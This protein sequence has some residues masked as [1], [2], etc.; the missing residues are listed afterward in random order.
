MFFKKSAFVFS[1]L[2]FLLI[3]FLN[4]SIATAMDAGGLAWNQ[5]PPFII[6]LLG[7]AITAI[8]SMM[9]IQS[10]N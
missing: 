1:I 9:S 6:G 8:F 2:A 7:M 3:A 5:Y 10:M 4:F